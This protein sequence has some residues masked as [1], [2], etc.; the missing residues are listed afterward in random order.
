MSYLAAHIKGLR[1]NAGLTQKQLAARA[2]VGLT[3]V[4]NIESEY[5]TAPAFK[6]LDALAK[7]FAADPDS[8]LS[9]MSVDVGER[10]KMVHVVH[11]I[12]NEK[13]FL[14]MDKI[15]ETVFIDRDELRGY[16]YMGIK[17]PDNSMIEDHICKGASV[18]IRQ[19]APIK[20]GDIVLAVCG[21]SD[22]IVRRYFS[23]GKEVLLSAS[24]NKELYP[25]IRI[26]V[27]KDRL[28]ILGK[29]VRWI[30]IVSE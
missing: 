14:E 3:T 17:M 21:D 2:G 4:K 5:L 16:E 20:N 22:G 9:R 12:S 24:G 26:D 29:L 7:V 11:S 19:D 6:I 13:P 18:I 30:N 1:K 15:V 8:L 28:V 27:E 10:S 23:D 25:D